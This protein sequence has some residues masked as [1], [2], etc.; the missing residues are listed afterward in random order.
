MEGPLHLNLANT[1]VSDR[2]GRDLLT[3][4]LQLAHWVAAQGEWT[5][6]TAIDPSRLADL[7]D[8]RTVIRS[9]LHTVLDEAEPEPAAVA[10]LNFYLAR[11][12]RI[13]VLVPAGAGFALERHRDGDAGDRL[14]A[15]IARSAA[16]SL[17]GPQ[18]HRLRACSGPA[19]RLFFEARH[20]GRRWCDSRVCGNRVRVARHRRGTAV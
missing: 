2:P 17:T 9:L 10:L 14:L 20:P 4:P 12:G 19:C 13:S 6:I 8:L 15:D 11:E 7:R 18:C 3:T 1:L 16:E 5:D